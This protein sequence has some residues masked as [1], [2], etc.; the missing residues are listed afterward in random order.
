MPSYR[1]KGSL[2][3]QLKEGESP[4]S[5]L[6]ALYADLGIHAASTSADREA[7]LALATRHVPGFR[8]SKRTGH[9]G[10]KKGL[11]PFIDRVTREFGPLFGSAV[12]DACRSDLY[13]LI[14]RLK[15][16]KKT[17]GGRRYTKK[18]LVQIISKTPSIAGSENPYYRI[19]PATLLSWVTHSGPSSDFQKERRD[20]FEAMVAKVEAGLADS[21]A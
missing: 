14:E 18:R 15:R 2:A 1:Y 9:R 12:E 6:P 16:T 20:K 10:R 19:N 5:K 3:K 21:E 13:H 11:Q 4:A 17:S 8:F 7:L